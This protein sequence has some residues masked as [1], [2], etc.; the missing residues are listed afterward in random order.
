MGCVQL[1]KKPKRMYWNSAR[2]KTT[3]ECQFSNREHL[4]NH[5]YI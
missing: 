4:T 3:K 2:R 1:D 5:E